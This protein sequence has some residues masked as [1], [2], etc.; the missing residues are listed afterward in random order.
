MKTY[1]TFVLELDETYTTFKH[2][3]TYNINYQSI[4]E[5]LL[6]I[7]QNFL[8]LPTS[9]MG[10]NIAEVNRVKKQIANA[11]KSKFGHTMHLATCV[12]NAVEY[13][14]SPQCVAIMQTEGISWNKEDFGKKVFGFQKSY[15]YK[16]I[17]AGNL[18]PAIIEGYNT[19]CDELGADADRSLAGLLEFSRGINVEVQEGAT[20]EEQAE[21]LAE[22]IAEAQVGD[23]VKTIFTMSFK[24]ES[25]KNVAVR[26]DANGLLTTQ[27]DVQDIKNAIAF[28]Q[29]QLPTA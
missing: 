7:E 9:K 16:L 10:F 28:L 22:A 20:E 6:T 21:A 13:F 29:A 8:S 27:N 23:R 3:I 15:F 4:M 11:Q 5:Q 24:P 14:D 12:K 1:P 26:I 18:A 17:K 25:G 19:K 2:N